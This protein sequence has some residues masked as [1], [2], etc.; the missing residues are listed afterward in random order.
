M[1]YFS[2]FPALIFFILLSVTPADANDQHSSNVSGATVLA[3]NDSST[4]SSDVIKV[5]DTSGLSE[6]EV[7]KIAQ[8]ADKAETEAVIEKSV[9]EKKPGIVSQPPRKEAVWEN[10][11]PT[12]TKFD[13][14]ELTSGEWLKGKFKAMYEKELE[15]DSKEMN[16]QTFDFDKIK[17]LRTY[18]I[19]TVNIVVEDKGHEGLFGLRQT[20]IE[21]TGVLRLDDQTVT[22]IRGDGPLE[23]QRKQIIS[24]VYG[25]EHEYEYWS[26][27]MTFGL[28]VR[29][30]NSE[31]FDFTTIAKIQRRS[32]K[33]RFKVDYI[34]NVFSANQSETANNHRIT[35]NFN[36]SLS[37]S[38]Y[39][40]PIFAEY[41]RDK[42]Q[43][44]SNQYTLGIGIGYIIVDTKKVDWDISGGPAIL[45][46]EYDTVEEGKDLSSKTGALELSTTYDVEI[47][48]RVDFNFNYRL[49][50]SRDDTGGYKHHMVTALENEITTWLDVDITF[51][52]DYTHNPQPNED[53]TVP[54]QNDLQLV[55]SLGVDF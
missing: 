39:Y 40:T 42:Y 8:E 2:F 30:G 20:T 28:D 4:E 41:F 45:Y 24:I 31:K 9:S 17:Q 14:I 34:G 33:T 47:T 35:E 12:P 29:R 15:F 22:I 43:N 11:S 21:V 53:K 13:W 26:G 37:K 32:S 6:E 25:G 7:S 27:K 46:T 50:L 18:R 44:I 49:T 54:E 36:V 3:A 51:I 19:V 10:L 48:K 1:K 38:F 5:E 23:F 55:V 16:L 52:W